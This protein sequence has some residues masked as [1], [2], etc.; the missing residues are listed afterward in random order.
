MN[1]TPTFYDSQSPVLSAAAQQMLTILNAQGAVAA[2][3]G[4]TLQQLVG[5][6]HDG[7]ITQPVVIDAALEQLQTQKLIGFAD[8]ERAPLSSTLWAV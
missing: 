6:C 4:V 1:N 2:E 3:S 7:G 5:W 8:D